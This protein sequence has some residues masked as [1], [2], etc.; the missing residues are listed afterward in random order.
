MV[1]RN[2]RRNIRN[3]RKRRNKRVGMKGGAVEIKEVEVKSSGCSTANECSTQQMEKQ[4]AEAEKQIEDRNQAGGADQKVTAQV[5]ANSSDDDAD[6]QAQIQK[7]AYQGQAQAEYD[8]NAG[9]IGGRRRKR[10]K[11]RRKSK[12]RKSKRRKSRIKSKRRKSKRRKSK[13]RKSKRRK[14]KRKSRK[15]YKRKK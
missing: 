11:S 8:K 4:A 5:V 14:S 10:R 9:T 12:R 15:K 1:T 3:R 7:I 13:R 2:N 6:L